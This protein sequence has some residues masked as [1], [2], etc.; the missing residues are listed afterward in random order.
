MSISDDELG[1]CF[2]LFVWIVHVRTTLFAK[3]ITAMSYQRTYQ[4]LWISFKT[5]DFVVE[6]ALCSVD[7]EAR[8]F[9]I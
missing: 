5:K 6:F 8:I 3:M 4:K 7:W 1:V 9:Y 2:S